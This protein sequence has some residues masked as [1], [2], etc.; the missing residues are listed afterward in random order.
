MVCVGVSISLV[1]YGD[2]VRRRVLKYEGVM[3]E[4]VAFRAE[5][6]DKETME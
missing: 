6:V 5:M 1:G 2:G 4:G 3:R